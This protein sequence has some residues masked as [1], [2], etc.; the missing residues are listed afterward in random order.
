MTRMDLA[1]RSRML[2]AAIAGVI[3]LGSVAAPAA[4]A[5]D[6]VTQLADRYSPIVVVRDQAVSCGAGEPFLPTPVDTVLGHTDVT[7]KGPGGQS[8]TGPTSADLASKGEG[9]YLDLP[10]NP[11]DPGCSYE[12]W[13]DRAAGGHPSTV[14]ARVA[15]DAGHP[16]MLALQYW[17]FWTYNDW[18]DKH[19]GDWEMIQ[20]LFDAA[21]PAAALDAG[22][23]S[24][25]FAQHEGS[26]T[27]DW[28]D[29]KLLKDGDHVVVYPGQGSHAAY[30]TQAQWFGKSA[31]AGFGCDSTVAPGRQVRPDVVVLP[32]GHTPGFEWTSFTGRWGQ[33]APS[34]N[35]GPTGPNTKTQWSQP[36]T[37]QQEQGR[38][39]AVSLP[40]VGGPAVESFCS[41]T[42]AGSLLFVR[43]LD[44]PALVVLV[45]LGF[46]V[47][48]LLLAK[49]TRWR[50]GDDRQPD[51][52]R[53]AGQVVTASFWLLGRHLR[54][55]WPL[56]VTI[57]L[58]AAGALALERLALRRRPT[59]GFTDVN[60]LSGH[61]VAAALAVLVAFALAPVMSV[62]LAA[63]C[64]VVE[65]I[66][67]NRPALPW[68]SILLAVRKPSGALVQ[69]VLYFVVTGLASSLFLLPVALLLISFWAVAMPAAVI[70]D[71]GFVAAF[72]RSAALTKGRR[73]RAVLLSA[74]L[75]WIGFSLPG[76][77]GGLLLLVT[78][79]P[80]WI[81]N[82]VSIV[83]SA[84]LLTLSAIGLTLQFY[85]FRQE[86]ARNG[87]EQAK[88]G[89]V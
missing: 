60:G 9:W 27:S 35:N 52:E 10:G 22:P 31:A 39:G 25:A 67:R 65:N 68:E 1:R 84:L 77:I 33:K 62:L 57:G 47:L 74:L 18:N 4:A 79:W 7:L 16:G 51:R 82:I 72:R 37:W 38:A 12:Q 34:F 8:I 55:L 3:A 75:V 66:A 41:I 89:I 30:Y 85:D 36:V 32:D 44:S 59:G 64:R 46:V 48:V 5:E 76:L 6:P 2:L 20:L 58:S 13:F 61:A 80:F 87:L 24:T 73:W 56:V 49:G 23:A 88:A 70:E 17:F 43:V 19:E 15:T 69:L 50:H 29:E 40:I 26:E 81:T 86:E 45:L 28:N 63:T 53:R 71:L 83:F 14:Y 11:L 78:G 42:A 54:R 21:S